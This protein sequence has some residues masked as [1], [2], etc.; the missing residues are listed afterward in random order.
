MPTWNRSNR[1]VA[2][3]RRARARRARARRG[4]GRE[5]GEHHNPHA[6][7]VRVRVRIRERFAAPQAVTARVGFRCV[8]TRPL[9]PETRRVSRARRAT[10]WVRSTELGEKHRFDRVDSE[11]LFRV[12]PATRAH[13]CVAHPADTRPSA[14]HV[15]RRH[16]ECAGARA[17]G[18]PGADLRVAGRLLRSRLRRARREP[19]RMRPSGSASIAEP[20]TPRAARSRT[21]R[22]S[23]TEGGIPCATCARPERARVRGPEAE[24]VQKHRSLRR[25][26]GGDSTSGD[27]WRQMIT[28]ACGRREPGVL[29]APVRPRRRLERGRHR[30]P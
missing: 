30:G 18:V 22:T 24:P 11:S 7:I 14:D 8:P 10:R 19:S 4:R 12:R 13:S 26:I 25:G 3:A 5:E 23:P 29:E 17:S 1:G 6:C 16:D 9:D 27:L 2:L 20:P 15:P 28:R 21:P